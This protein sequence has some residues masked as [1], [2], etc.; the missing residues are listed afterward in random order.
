M[1]CFQALDPLHLWTE[2]PAI[3]QSQQATAAATGQAV[4]ATL[5]GQRESI[6][7][8]EKMYDKIRADQAP[9]LAIAPKSL[10]SLQSAVYDSPNFTPPENNP[11]Y[12]WQKKR[13][14][15]DLGNQ[16]NLLG[17]GRGSTVQANATARALGDL[18]ANE[19]DKGYSRDYAKKQDYIA[20]LMNLTNIARGA[21]T[22][23][24]GAGS[25]MAN[26]NSATALGTGQSLASLYS[27]QGT[28]NANAV[29]AGS[30][31]QQNLYGG[32]MNLG[33]M[34]LMA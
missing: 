31:N 11:A 1:G 14:L 7:S 13:T 23:V 24:A 25:S 3:Q 15:E 2:D 21:G 34:A 26:N 20:N 16:M 18:N 12:E 19:Y 27:N 4:D 28:N 22:T 33:G 29:L 17:R 8:Q 5:Q 10:E 6:A 32:L 30:R 9:F